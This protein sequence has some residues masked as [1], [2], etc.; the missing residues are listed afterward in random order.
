MRRAL[1]IALVLA[2]CKGD[3]GPAEGKIMPEPAVRFE[4]S[5]GTWVVRV[6]L[7][8]TAEQR[9]RGLMFRPDLPRDRGMLFLFDETAMHSFWMRNTLIALDLIFLG[10][11]RSVVGVVANA[12]PRTDT[13]R[14]VERPSR[15]VL[16]VGG[17]EAAAHAV[18]PGI[19]AVFL[20]VP[21]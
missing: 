2:S 16:E 4:T 18:G 5:R 7:A 20:G 13:M 12:E 17:G 19:R 6:E 8:R 10:E 15:Y 14:T 21:E 3:G 11:D 1:L 9:A